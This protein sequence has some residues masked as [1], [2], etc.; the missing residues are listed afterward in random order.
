M[1]TKAR[2]DGPRF[3][4]QSRIWAETTE[5]KALSTLS[6]HIPRPKLPWV[7]GPFF[8]FDLSSSDHRRVDNLFKNPNSPVMRILAIDTCSEVCAAA[9]LGPKET[10]VE[11]SISMSRG[12]AERLPQIIADLLD[13]AGLSY[14]DLD[15]IAVTVGPGTFTGIRIGVSLARGLG[16]VLSIP[17]VGIS[18]LAALSHTA[19]ADGFG[20][21][22]V[23]VVLDAK[24][25][26]FYGQAFDEAGE[27]L[28]P[29]IVTDAE[30][31][32]DTVLDPWRS[33]TTHDLQGAFAL[34]GTGA[35]PLVTALP[36]LASH[37]RKH[38][39]LWPSIKSVAELGR[40]TEP[41]T[42]PAK[43][44]YL[45]QPDAKPPMRS[46]VVARA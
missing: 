37:V 23:A 13:Q 45:R 42:A 39:P 2:T 7:S 31:V 44:L 12:H 34:V 16:L 8:P 32:S 6:H 27:E 19:I 25:G 22:G 43:P 3:A 33:E 15:R 1:Q 17:V 4:S 18:T 28:C 21:D 14:R 10:C 24:R 26:E 46:S 40:R 20:G 11:T 29:P 38:A 30:H 41:E 36:C 9:I 5:L 35:E